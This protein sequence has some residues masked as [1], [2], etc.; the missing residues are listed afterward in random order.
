MKTTWDTN[1]I[2]FVHVEAYI[3]AINLQS[4]VQYNYIVCDAVLSH[5]NGEYFKPL[6]GKIFRRYPK[7]G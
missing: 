3:Q 6:G 7:E 2:S 5:L 1:Q 4:D